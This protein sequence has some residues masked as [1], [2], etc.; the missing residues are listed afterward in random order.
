MSKGEIEKCRAIKYTCITS[1]T[2]GE[3]MSTISLR[4]TEEEARLI[5]GYA[6]ANGLNVSTFI[7]DL[8]LDKIEEDFKL[9]EE[10]ILKASKRIG[11][12][13]S[14]EHTDVWKRLGV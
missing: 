11:K 6:S 12:E 9:D 4:V 14:H 2:K 1:N 7:R 10:R 13:K 5:K 8:T 3:F